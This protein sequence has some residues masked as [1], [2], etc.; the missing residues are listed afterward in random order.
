MLLEGRTIAVIEDDPVMGE[1]L[2]QSV[3]AGAIIPH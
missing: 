1:S 2:L 3:K